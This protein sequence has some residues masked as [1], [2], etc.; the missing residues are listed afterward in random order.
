[1]NE[2]ERFREVRARSVDLTA[3][4]EVDDQLAQTMADVSPTK[5]HLAH[6]T[7]FFE[8][9][10]LAHDPEHRPVDPRH[11]ILFNSYY[12]SVGA[13]HPRPQRSLITRPTLAQVHAYRVVID[14]AI[15][16][17][18]AAGAIEGPAAFALEVGLHH[19]EQHQ[20]LILTDIKHVLG[21]SLIQAPYHECL[22]AA[23]ARPRPAPLRFRG[24]AGGERW[25]GHDG[26]G[27]AFDNE[28]PRHRV[29][30]EPFAL[31]NRTVTNGEL[32]EFIA[33]GGYTRPELWTSD[34]WATAQR[35][36]WRAPLYWEEQGGAWV[37]Y[38]F[39]GS[40]PVDDDEPA[41]HLSWYEADAYA[42]WAG[43][44]LPSEAEWEV[45]L[46]EAG[47]DASEARPG[48]L[49][50]P[51]P[52]AGDGLLQLL[53]GVWEW[54]MSPYVPYPRFRP[55]PGAFAEYNGKFMSSQMVLRGGSCL[56]PPGH[57]RPTYRNFFPPAARWQMSGLRLARWSE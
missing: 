44:R 54:T 32:R 30:V 11:D 26:R 1:M 6:T 25:I 48:T 8:R 23:G 49:F 55:W 28:G 46:A 50:H 34:G 43:A 51:E 37:S 4:L 17:R 45:A 47:E 5:W 33:D 19:E 40:R 24:F 56:S 41:C 42:R 31:A 16:R 21:T 39:S 14:E 2:V 53:G 13:R 10:V 18:L 27:F 57:V 12:E 38:T 29:L 52:A 36:G 9:F 7:W 20:E 22:P 15:E 3:S 35:E